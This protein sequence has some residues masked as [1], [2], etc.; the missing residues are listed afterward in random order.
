MNSATQQQTTTPL[1]LARHAVGMMI[2][3]L[4]SPYIH[5][6]QQPIT[7][8]VGTWAAPLGIA[9]LAYG[10]FAL[11][12]TKKAKAAWPKSFL[13]LAWACLALTVASPYIDQVSQRQ[14]V[15]RPAPA[16][17][18][19]QPRSGS[20]TADPMRPPSN[21]EFDPSTA[22]KQGTGPVDGDGKPC[23][24]ITEARGE[25]RRSFT[26]E[27]ATGTQAC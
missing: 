2:L 22:R 16:G 24:P 9:L 7:T 13:I 19:A 15:E 11:F 21:F 25:C 4:A 10:L 17:Q 3:A 12:F 6:S 26:Y 1:R 18:Q 27:E 20:P 23:T 14:Q 5:Y 8:W